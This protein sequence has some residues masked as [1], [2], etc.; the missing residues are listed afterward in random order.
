MRQLPPAATPA[1]C[2]RR[3]AADEYDSVEVRLANRRAEPRAARPDPSAVV[4]SAAGDAD[5]R[6][7][8]L[9]PCSRADQWIA[10]EL[11][12]PTT[13]AQFVEVG[14]L[15][16]DPTATGGR[17]IIVGRRTEPEERHRR[18]RVPD[19]VAGGRRHPGLQP[20][21]RQRYQRSGHPGEV[22][23]S[24]RRSTGRG[25]SASSAAAWAVTS[26][27]AWRRTPRIRAIR[28][29]DRLDACRSPRW[30][31]PAFAIARSRTAGASATLG[32]GQPEAAAAGPSRPT[33]LGAETIGSAAAR[34]AGAVS[35]RSR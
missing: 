35:P 22:R 26:S 20:G 10:D 28:P 13:G 17:M 30:N 7:R 14:P 32:S 29:P 25:R 31:K 16:A 4:V 24:D 21:L 11:V 19:A 27:S 2:C 34:V 23:H 5:R 33:L 3:C 12:W 6:V 8:V 18:R 1:E 9:G 15:P